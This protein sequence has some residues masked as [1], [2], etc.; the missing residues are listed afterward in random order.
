MGFYM[1]TTNRCQ[2][3]YLFPNKVGAW[4]FVLILCLE[5][6]TSAANSADPFLEYR[7]AHRLVIV[8]ELETSTQKADRAREFFDTY[9]C[10]TDERN[11]RLLIFKTNSPAFKTLPVEMQQRLGIWLVGYD[12]AVK[13]F[14]ADDSLLSEVLTYIDGMYI[15]KQEL[16]QSTSKC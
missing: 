5:T 1:K 13:A 9:P 2:P 16:L 11:M 4:L 14:S 10:E 8:T 7:W 3:R 15:R 12:G 6:A